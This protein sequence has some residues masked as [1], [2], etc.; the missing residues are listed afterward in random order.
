MPVPG[1]AVDGDLAILD[2]AQESETGE[3]GGEGEQTECEMGGVDSG[4]DVE[5]VDCG[6][7]PAIEGVPLAGKLAPG[8]PLAGDE[9]G[10]EQQGCAEPGK[11]AAEGGAAHAQPFFDDVKLVEDVAAGNLH[12]Q[13][14]EDE[15][16]GVQEKNGWELDWMPVADELGGAHVKVAGALVGEEHDGQGEE[17]H[18]VAGEGEED[19]Q[20]DALEQFSW[21]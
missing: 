17:E 12:G 20:A 15:Y 9:E 10:T 13:A 11:G 5:E 7:C 21:T 1:E 18:H 3:A 19:D 16:G 14:A 2:F 4:D 8:G 6:G